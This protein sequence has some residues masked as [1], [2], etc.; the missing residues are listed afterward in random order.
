MF[1]FMRDAMVMVSLHS[2]ETL[3]KSGRKD[4]FWKVHHGEKDLITGREH[5]ATGAASCLITSYST[6]ESEDLMARL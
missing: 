2:N 5:T 3:T 1:T 4:F 6:Q